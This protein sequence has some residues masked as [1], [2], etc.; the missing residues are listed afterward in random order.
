MLSPTQSSGQPRWIQF[1]PYFHSPQNSH[2]PMVIDTL[3]VERR[4]SSSRT[5]TICHA[6]RFPGKEDPSPSGKSC[7][8][9][10]S[11]VAQ[12]RQVPL[13]SVGSWTWPLQHSLEKAMR[14]KGWRDVGYLIYQCISLIVTVFNR[15]EWDSPSPP[16]SLCSPPLRGRMVTLSTQ[17]Q[18]HYFLQLCF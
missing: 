13:T 17:G 2:P 6:R 9:S 7:A 5:S 1:H 12:P 3:P 16:P 8:K 11:W 18:S 15:S 4:H 14:P 10:Y